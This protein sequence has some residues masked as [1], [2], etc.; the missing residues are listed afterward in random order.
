MDKERADRLEPL[1]EARDSKFFLEM[2][3]AL[4]LYHILRKINRVM[5]LDTK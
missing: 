4:F 3:E 2:D 1:K 5:T